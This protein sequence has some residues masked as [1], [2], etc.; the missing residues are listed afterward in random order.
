ME[1]Q[2][3][4]PKGKSKKEKIIVPLTPDFPGFRVLLFYDLDYCFPSIAT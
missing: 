2:A 1:G 3:K 4:C